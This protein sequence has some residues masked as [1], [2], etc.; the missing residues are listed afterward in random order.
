MVQFAFRNSPPLT[1]T[2]IQCLFAHSWPDR[3]SDE[4]YSPVLE[5]SLGCI[6]AYDGDELVGFVNVAW[7]GGSHGFILDTTVAPEY[8][9]Q[10]VGT[11]LLKRAAQL[12]RDKG[13]V[14][15]Q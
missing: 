7:D 1:N 5:R 8:R 14:W 2:D 6:C 9:R 11:E 13:L 3:N 4:D 10:G 12:A 15:L